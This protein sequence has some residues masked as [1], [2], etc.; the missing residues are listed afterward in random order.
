M[1]QNLDAGFFINSGIINGFR[2]VITGVG[3]LFYPEKLVEYDVITGLVPLYIRTRQKLVFFCFFLNHMTKSL[4]YPGC[5]K[6][7]RKS[8]CQP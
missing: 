2:S 7:T 6:I 4:F 5:L 3:L 1:V 8:K